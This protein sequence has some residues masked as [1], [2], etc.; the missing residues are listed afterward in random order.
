[1]NDDDRTALLELACAAEARLLHNPDEGLFWEDVGG[2]FDW[3][4]WVPTHA[5][6]GGIT[7][8]LVCA[9]IDSDGRG[10]IRGCADHLRARLTA[11]VLP[12]GAV[13]GPDKGADRLAVE[14]VPLLPSEVKPVLTLM[15]TM[16]VALRQAEP[17]DPAIERE[18]RETLARRQPRG[19]A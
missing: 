19:V 15:R 11:I 12:G 16:F 17:M 6:V 5:L 2:G 7:A 10:T 3:D 1:M 8:R 18:V 13:H 14:L 9:R 4:P